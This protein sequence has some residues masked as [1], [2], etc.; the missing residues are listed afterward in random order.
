MMLTPK[1]ASV[2]FHHKEGRQITG[3]A[4]HLLVVNSG[5]PKRW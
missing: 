1:I 2:V 4:M 3:E 5:V